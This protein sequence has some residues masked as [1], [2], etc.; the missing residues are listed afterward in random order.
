MSLEVWVRVSP[1]LPC[2]GQDTAAPHP[3]ALR[4]WP[5]LSPTMSGSRGPG[6]YH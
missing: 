1:T 2:E 3:P 5:V 6:S 4:A